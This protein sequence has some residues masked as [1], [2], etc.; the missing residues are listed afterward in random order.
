M[1][2]GEALWKLD[3]RT[4]E[5]Y[6]SYRDRTK[7]DKLRREKCTSVSGTQCRTCHSYSVTSSYAG[8][9]IKFN[10][11]PLRLVNYGQTDARYTHHLLPSTGH[12]TRCTLRQL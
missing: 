10:L 1:S 4:I 7:L 11:S 9:N 3:S 6:W 12:N 5:R 2:L 8:F